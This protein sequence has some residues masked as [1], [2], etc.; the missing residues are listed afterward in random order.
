[1]FIFSVSALSI[2]RS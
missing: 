1:M 2:N